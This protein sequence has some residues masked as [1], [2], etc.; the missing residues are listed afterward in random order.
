MKRVFKKIIHPFKSFKNFVETIKRR[1]PQSTSQIANDAKN[2]WS[3]SIDSAKLRDFSHWKGEGRWNDELSW[4]RIGEKHFSMYETLCV[5]TNTSRPIMSMV[6]WGPGG[7][8]N[9]VKFIN[10]ID[11][12][13]GV[14]ISDAN[15]AECKL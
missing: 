15:L 12:F 13:F 7:G 4:D 6:E 10:E 8:A 9:A 2:F 11:E 1:F 3:Q 14:D 5:L